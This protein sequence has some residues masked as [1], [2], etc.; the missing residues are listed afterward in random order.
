MEWSALTVIALEVVVT[1]G[2]AVGW[3]HR[4]AQRTIEKFEGKMDHIDECLHRIEDKRSAGDGRL[5]A[6]LDEQGK[7]IARIEGRLGD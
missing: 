7:A 2:L 1:V 5:H 3:I 6:R 4:Q